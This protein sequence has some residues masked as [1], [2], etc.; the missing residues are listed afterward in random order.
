MRH[1]LAGAT[2]RTLSEEGLGFIAGWEGFYP[3]PYNDAGNNA[4]IGYGH[5]I[6]LGKVTKRDRRKWGKISRKRGLRLLK[7]E[8]ECDASVVQVR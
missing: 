6:H 3:R 2:E 8:L 1:R 4:T 7:R 5:L